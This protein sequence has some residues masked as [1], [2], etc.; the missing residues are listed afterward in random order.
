M[1][2]R[3]AVALLL[4]LLLLHFFQHGRSQ[5]NSTSPSNLPTLQP[6][7][8]VPSIIRF[9]VDE[10]IGLLTFYF[11]TEVDAS[12]F[13]ATRIYLQSNV[14]L[15]S[16]VNGFPIGP[17]S[18]NNLS[19]Q[20]NTST[21]QYYLLDD[22]YADYMISSIGRYRSQ[23]FLSYQN[24]AFYSNLNVS[25]AGLLTIQALQV[26]SLFPDTRQPYVKSFNVDMNFGHLSV[27]FSEPVTNFR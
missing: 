18:F 8:I 21:L 25:T 11:N 2:G 3:S 22:V 19:L 10:S 4:R 14:S 17:Y 9:N 5:S 12:T 23:T 7:S 6:T 20:G 24:G 1:N 26:S 16:Y 13:D 27:T 15:T